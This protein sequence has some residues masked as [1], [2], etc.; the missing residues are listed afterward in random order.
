MVLSTQN[1]NIKG[2]DIGTKGI[3]EVD[4]FT[5]RWLMSVMLRTYFF[6]VNL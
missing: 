5:K 2:F 6:I 4:N 3:V 1:L